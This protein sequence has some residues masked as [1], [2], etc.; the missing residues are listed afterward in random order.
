MIPVRRQH[1]AM[2]PLISIEREHLPVAEA[3]FTRKDFVGFRRARL[4]NG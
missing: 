1:S 3:L 2:Q 4:F